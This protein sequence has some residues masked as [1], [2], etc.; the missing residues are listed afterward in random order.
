MTDPKS[1]FDDPEFRLPPGINIRHQAG[2]KADLIGQLAPLLAADG[3][4]IANLP[5]A[6]PEVLNA[7]LVRAVERHNMQLSTPVGDQRARAI[8]TLRDLTVALHAEN[9]A[10]VQNLFGTIGPAATRHRPSSGHLTGITMETLDVLFR[11]VVP[12]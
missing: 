1:P 4:D 2:A 6:D 9:V 3:I 11:A 12:N 10:E 7:A 5:D 8:N